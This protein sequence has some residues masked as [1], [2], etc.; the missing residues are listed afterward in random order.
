VSDALTE[1]AF[2]ILH[3]VVLVVA[4]ALAFR[5][6][7]HVTTGFEA[8]T[9]TA[10]DQ[11]SRG[12]RTAFVVGSV[13]V[14][15][16]TLV[17]TQALISFPSHHAVAGSSTIPSFDAP[18][19]PFSIHVPDTWSVT[20]RSQLDGPLVFDAGNLDDQNSVTVIEAPRTGPVDLDAF[21]ATLTDQLHVEGTIERTSVELPGGH[22]TC[23]ALTA[24]EDGS[25]F[26]HRFYLFENELSMFLVTVSG[27]TETFASSASVF[28]GVVS[29]F[30]MDASGQRA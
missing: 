19:H 21:E 29:S 10:R 13:V 26:D 22:A 12:R 1:N 20:D 8:Q 4:A 17:G 7:N 14:L 27:P 23:F 25:R 2:G 28:D 16:A 18:G 9:G 24:N 5:F 6:V 3:E 30:R 15:I 11:S